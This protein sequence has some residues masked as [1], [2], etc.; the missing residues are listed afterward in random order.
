MFQK[1]FLYS[2]QE[3][4]SHHIAG[5]FGELVRF[6]LWIPVMGLLVALVGYYYQPLTSTQMTIIFS[7][8]FLLLFVLLIYRILRYIRENITTY[9]VDEEG[10]LLVLNMSRNAAS[11]MN[12]QSVMQGMQG[13]KLKGMMSAGS[14]VREALHNVDE[15]EEI[16]K[17]TKAGRVIRKIEKVVSGKKTITLYG[18]IGRKGKLVIRRVYEDCSE[19]EQYCLHLSEGKDPEQF[20]FYKKTKAEDFLKPEKGN[21]FFRYSLGFTV[22]VLWLFLFGFSTDINAMAKV[23]HGIYIEAQAVVQTSV[24][25]TDGEWE[26]VLQYQAEGE[27]IR[28]TLRTKN[29]TYHEG[30]V[31]DLYYLKSQPQK[32]VFQ[33]T[34]E[35]HIGPYVVIWLFGEALLL[36]FSLFFK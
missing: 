11:Y 23:R 5:I 32:Y 28:D 18:D 7:I 34:I 29:E 31:I 21:K 36:I 13:T 26:A 8:T 20:E 3:R 24:K 6:A 30:E 16:Q 1:L 22:G 25:N 17:N 2:V 14:A 33:S 35:F 4:R 9:A 10:N 19:L 15:E 27:S 12:L